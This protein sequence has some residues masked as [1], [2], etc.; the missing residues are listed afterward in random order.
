M[1]TASPRRTVSE[2]VR[3]WLQVPR[4]SEMF[5]QVWA[6]P[7]TAPASPVS[8]PSHFPSAWRWSSAQPVPALSAPSRAGPWPAPPRRPRCSGPSGHQSTHD[9]LPARRRP[10]RRPRPAAAPRPPTSSPAGR[11]PEGPRS[12]RFHRLHRPPARARAPAAMPEPVSSIRSAASRRAS[13]APC[14]RAPVAVIAAPTAPPSSAHAGTN[15]GQHIR[16]NASAGSAAAAAPTA[17]PT[18]SAT[19]SASLA[20]CRTTPVV[21]SISAIGH[22]LLTPDPLP[23]PGCTNTQQVPHEPQADTQQI[24]RHYDTPAKS[25][26]PPHP[27]QATTHKPHTTRTDAAHHGR[28]T[29]AGL[30]A[31]PAR[32]APPSPHPPGLLGVSWTTLKAVFQA[33]CLAARCSWPTSPC[34][35]CPRAEWSRF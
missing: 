15:N 7:A 23:Q 5:V 26:Q 33:A 22:T 8:S 10:A 1:R 2:V 18:S 16:P 4:C 9:R 35:L 21:N 31:P 28:A 3:S 14:V 27:P 12:Q 30:A 25:P 19:V 11:P 29:T 13:A 32:T 24:P 34:V 6:P 20:P 17:V